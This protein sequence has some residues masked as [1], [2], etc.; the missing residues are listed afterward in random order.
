MSRKIVQRI[1]REVFATWNAVRT[2]PELAIEG[3]A[4]FLQ[5]PL[6]TLVFP[7]ERRVRHNQMPALS[8]TSQRFLKSGQVVY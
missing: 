2:E 5:H 4:F 7:I 1:S 8:Q 6:S 3:I